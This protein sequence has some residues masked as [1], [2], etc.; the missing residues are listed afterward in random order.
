MEA[1]LGIMTV[2]L[3]MTCHASTTPVMEG[4]VTGC[5]I[6]LPTAVSATRRQVSLITEDETEKRELGFHILTISTSSDAQTPDK[7]GRRAA[8]EEQDGEIV[9]GVGTV[10][11]ILDLFTQTVEQVFQRPIRVFGREEF[12]QALFSE[13]LPVWVHGFGQTVGVEQHGFA[14]FQSER[15]LSEFEKIQDSEAQ[16]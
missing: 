5:H 10:S 2:K 16:A 1:Q 7:S 9:I 3:S 13:F 14:F 11:E 6:I 4:V 15:T 12:S 8:S